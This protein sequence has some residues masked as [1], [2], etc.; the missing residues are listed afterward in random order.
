MHN[1][2]ESVKEK[3]EEKKTG[4][5]GSGRV[6]YMSFRV[7]V[8]RRGESKQTIWLQRNSDEGFGA[9]KRF[10]V[11]VRCQISIGSPYTNDSKAASSLFSLCQDC[12]SAPGMDSHARSKLWGYMFCY[13]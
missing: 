12:P 11:S 4:G 9:E 3:S 5:L 2:A 1:G 8:K 7:K 6:R 13:C 10:T